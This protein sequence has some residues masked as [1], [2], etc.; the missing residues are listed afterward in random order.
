MATN[1]SAELQNSPAVR[2][3]GIE[4][5]E[6]AVPKTQRASDQRHGEPHDLRDSGN[7]A[8]KNPSRDIAKDWTLN[9]KLMSWTLPMSGVLY[10]QAM[11]S[12]AV[13][14]NVVIDTAAV[15]VD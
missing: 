7:V 10:F 11:P 2:N 3:A 4:S 15:R 9:Q 8:V 5:K 12:N 13:A 14:Q 1:E 6:L